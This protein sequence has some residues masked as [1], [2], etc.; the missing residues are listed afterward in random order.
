MLDLIPMNGAEVG[1][2]TRHFN[3]CSDS[4]LL[5]LLALRCWRYAWM[6]NSKT[7]AAVGQ[8]VACG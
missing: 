8:V 7:A 5:R 4:R 1:I 2:R 3:T 6:T